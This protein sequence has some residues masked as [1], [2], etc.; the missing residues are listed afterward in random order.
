MKNVT[1]SLK[2]WILHTDK[3]VIYTGCVLLV[4]MK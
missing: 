4:L 2:F 1:A 3:F